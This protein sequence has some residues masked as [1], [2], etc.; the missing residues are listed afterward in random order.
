MVQYVNIIEKK[1]GAAEMKLGRWGEDI[2]E[3]YLKKKGYLIVERNF[4]CRLG[5]IDIIARD[6]ADLVFVEVKTRQNQSYG[7][8]CEAINAAKVRH[9]K[10]T[11]VYYMTGCAMEYQDVRLDVIEILT[12]EGKTYL[13]H[14]ENITG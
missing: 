7:L 10:R 14:I 2:A 5:E 13:H 6:G 8:P 4:R 9:I 12:Q 11:A 1:D 3:K